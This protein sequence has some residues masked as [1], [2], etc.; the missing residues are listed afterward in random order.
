MQKLKVGQVLWWVQ[1]GVKKSPLRDGPVTVT[2]IGRKWITLSNYHRMDIE[3]WDADGGGFS[4][5]GRCYVSE[6]A[7]RYECAMTEKW[8]DLRR[9]VSSYRPPAGVSLADIEAALVRLSGKHTT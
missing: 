3:T 7:Y 9:L 2:R 6:E 8:G 4:S 5:P 1:S